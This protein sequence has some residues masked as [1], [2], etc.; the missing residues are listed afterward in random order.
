VSHVV[1]A[2]AQAYTTQDLQNFASLLHPYFAFSP[3]PIPNRP[4]GRAYEERAHRRMFR[5][6]DL[7]P[8]DVP[9]P[10]ALRLRSIDIS[11]EILRSSLASEPA[12]LTTLA[13]ATPLP[14]RVWIVRAQANVLA[15]TLGPTDYQ[16]AS[17]QELALAPIPEAPNAL[18]IFRWY[19]STTPAGLDLSR[20]SKQG[21]EGISWRALR[22]LYDGN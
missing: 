12:T 9:V 8:G 2:L 11:L 4:W 20:H 19:E 18:R 21:V 13:T 7:A 14:R 17:I 5:P 22:R 3:D 1:N 10:A 15:R 16:I 6:D